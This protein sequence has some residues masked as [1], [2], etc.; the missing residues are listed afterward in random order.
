[1]LARESHIIITEVEIVTFLEEEADI[2][3]MIRKKIT[4]LVAVEALIIG[5]TLKQLAS[6]Q[7]VEVIHGQLK[8]SDNLLEMT[9]MVAGIRI[10]K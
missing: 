5:L 9:V 1:M 6:P 2:I 7:E 10:R 3:K 8:K 4:G